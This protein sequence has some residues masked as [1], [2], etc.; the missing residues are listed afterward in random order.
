[1][2]DHL[3]SAVRNEDCAMHRALSEQEVCLPNISHAEGLI[4]AQPKVEID[5]SFTFL[6]EN[7]SNTNGDGF[8]ANA[9]VENKGE[10]YLVVG[11]FNDKQFA[12]ERLLEYAN[13]DAQII[14]NHTTAKTRYRVVLGP[15][16]NNE[17]T[18]YLAKLPGREKYL[19]W[20]LTLCSGN[21]NPPP[22]ENMI[23]VQ[24]EQVARAHK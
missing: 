14:N 15:I 2:S 24:T 1:M 3:I 17:L 12:Q 6:S 22:C 13:F 5:S 11:S 4:A 16:L 8:Q 20:Q 10:V 18:N 7:D 19:P 23:L 9:R 21:M